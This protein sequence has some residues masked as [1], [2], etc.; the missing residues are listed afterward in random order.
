[1]KG[2]QTQIEE[3][4]RS[5]FTD[6]YAMSIGELMSMYKEF[7]IDVH[8]EF[9][10]SF[11]WDL[12]QKSSFLESILLGIPVPPIFIFHRED[13]IWDVIDGQQRL[14]TLFEFSG[15]YRDE[16]GELKEPIKLMKTK[17]LPALENIVWEGIEEDYQFTPAQR[18]LV[19]RAKIDIRI[20]KATSDPS[21]KYDLFQRLNS[22]GSH[23]SPQEVRTCL[24]IMENKDLFEQLTEMA[25]NFD[26]KATLPLTERAISQQED[27]EFIV[28]FIVARHCKTTNMPSSLHEH[29]DNSII[30]LIQADNIDF[31]EEKEIF[32][33]TFNLLNKML[34]GDCFKRYNHEK[35]TFEGAITISAFEAMAPAVSNHLDFYNKFEATSFRDLVIRMH[36]HTSYTHAGR[37]STDRFKALLQVGGDIFN[38]DNNTKL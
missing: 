19:K 14:S 30:S 32:E 28:K 37:R 9:Q 34:G 24:I 3:A 36:K 6:S 8:P 7:E 2:L 1:M 22:G 23:L 5:I 10:R 17:F 20:L 33:S 4:S 38:G 11:R 18:I 21:A 12:S 13:G 26:F 27:L 31:K 25:L 16:S 35:R 29:L 15:I